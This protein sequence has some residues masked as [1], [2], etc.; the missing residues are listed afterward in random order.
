M[1]YMAK[2]FGAYGDIT[3]EVMANA[4]QMTEE[5]QKEK[6]SFPIKVGETY[7]DRY[8]YAVA[9][10]DTPH[11]Y[12]VAAFWDGEYVTWIYNETDDGFYHGH[13]FG[14]KQDMIK[15]YLKRI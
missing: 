15:D 10:K 8:I 2:G 3:K 6:E 9:Q 4:L 12:V 1:K 11:L 5:A 7:K 14:N 13:Y